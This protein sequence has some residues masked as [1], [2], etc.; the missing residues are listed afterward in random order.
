MKCLNCGF[1]NT[2][3]AVFCENCGKK[4]ENICPNC[5]YGN[6]VGA[7][8][9]RKCG[10]KL[11]KETSKESIPIIPTM[12]EELSEKV[13]AIEKNLK[14]SR[15][16]VAIIFA[17]V[18]GFTAMVE[19]IDPEEVTERMNAVFKRLSEIIYG[20]EGYID[21]FIGDCVM[22]LF[23][24]PIAHEDDPLRSVLCA[25]D[26]QSAMKEFKNMEISIG[27]NYGKVVA[28]GVGSDQ[29]MEYTVMGDVVNL[30]QRLESNAGKGEI[31]VSEKIHHKTNTEIEYEELKPIHIKGKKKLITPYK[32][33]SVRSKYV[34]CKIDEI[35]IIGRE[36]ELND[37]LNIFENVK[38]GNGQIVSVI[39]EA[40]IGKSKL[41]YEFESQ[42]LSKTGKKDE[43]RVILL[44]GRGIDYLKN[45][46]YW[47]L[48]QILRQLIGFK[49]TSSKKDISKAIE[50][51]IKSYKD[52]SFN[53][54]IPLLK[55]LFSS[56]MSEKEILIV[57]KMKVEGR[58]YVLNRLI[59][60]MFQA[61]A[62]SGPVIIVFEDLHWID[63]KTLKFCSQFAKSIKDSKILLILLFRSEFT[64]FEYSNLKEIEEISKL[65]NHY[66]INL[67]VLPPQKGLE[68]AKQI[69]NCNKIDIK[70]KKLLLE[71]SEGNPLYIEE[72]ISLLSDGKLVETEKGIVKLNVNEYDT[73]PLRLNELIM[74]KVDRLNSE[75]KGVIQ[76]ASV[77]GKEFS[78]KILENIIELSAQLRACLELIE[79][80]DLICRITANIEMVLKGEDKYTFK[81]III[82]DVVYGSMLKAERNKYHKLVGETFE[83][84]YCDNIDD[85]LE[86]LIYH[87][88]HCKDK[89]KLLKYVI[90]LAEKENKAGQYIKAEELYEEWIEIIGK[91]VFKSEEYIK[92]Y[93]TLASIKN[94]LAKYD[95][96]IKILKEIELKAKDL[97]KGEIL[98]RVLLKRSNIL[99]SKG[100][101]DK[102]LSLAIETNDI[103]RKVS[104]VDKELIGKCY[105]S[106][107]I[108][109]YEKSDYKRALEYHQKSLDVWLKILG[110][111]HPSMAKSYN[112]IGIVYYEK[113]DYDRALEYFQ[114]SLDVWLKSFGPKHPSIATSYNN[115][116]IVYYEK[117]DYKRAIE[118]YQK[119]LDVWLK[120]LGSQHPSVA[121]SYNNI[122]IVYY[123]KGDYKH[124]LE[125]HQKSLDIEL[126]THGPE[127]PSVATSYNNIGIVYFDK[128]DYNR[129]LE[130]YQ[131]SLDIELKVH[132]PKHP[133][134]A[135]NYK[136]IGTI[137]Y[138]KGEYK[139]AIEYFQK[140]LDIELKALGPEHP[141]VARTYNFFGNVYFKKNNPKV[142]FD[143]FEKAYRIFL[144]K[145]GED[146]TDTNEIRF[147]MAKSLKML[148]QTDKSLKYL[149]KAI[150]V[151]KKKKTKWIAQA[152]ELLKEIE[153]KQ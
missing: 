72:L 39:G 55:Y 138:K 2:E 18:S 19:G 17:D 28:G 123:D 4:I 56:E 101:Y 49:E 102:S 44:E 20:Y 80:N 111:E 150:S 107:G 128:G 137:Y 75:L 112:N 15:R 129:A 83:K 43:N 27:I 57:E 142:A 14:G 63:D 77:I 36:K 114:K 73:I 140:S 100:E 104:D 96:G 84:V 34:T 127:H 145:L 88:R 131:K 26:M 126:K 117:G 62:K 54:I 94:K 76:I 152:E 86:V 78:T 119:S 60:L 51:F 47:S 149:K 147:E 42:M 85:Y 6:R 74:A 30:A 8:F 82:R 148:N 92:K 65:S 151:G 40:G 45:S 98:A 58:V 144:N 5:K 37:L 97:V 10:T 68:L 22:V 134:L 81:N 12:P 70:L 32:P 66:Q 52:R 106:I 109:H 48:K 136:G 99:H 61:V 3:D 53:Q 64:S 125:Y 16:D 87:F 110:S 121:K 9:C 115:I 124:A 24:A 105:S 33:V 11:S 141:S 23:G 122:G 71:R 69:L 91:G 46:D 116:G 38:L 153:R 120:S 21:K 90:R 35:P 89:E 146:H 118:Y 130:Y 95:E 13:N 139:Q 79:K 59:D 133:Y 31:Y 41:I 1:E 25:V 135:R 132:G 103:L 29:K 143:W 67:S 7:K 93:I 113:G 108:I 50:K